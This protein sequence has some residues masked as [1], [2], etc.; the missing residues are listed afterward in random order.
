MIGVQLP[1]TVIHHDCKYQQRHQT[2][3]SLVVTKATQKWCLCWADQLE[4]DM[5]LNYCFNDKEIKQRCSFMYCEIFPK[6]KSVTVY[7]I[8]RVQSNSVFI[9]KGV[10]FNVFRLK[11]HCL[12][13]MLSRCSMRIITIDF[14]QSSKRELISSVKPK[15]ICS[16]RWEVTSLCMDAFSVHPMNETIDFLW[17]DKTFAFAVVFSIR[18][19]FSFRY[20]LIGCQE[21]HDVDNKKEIHS[22]PSL[23]K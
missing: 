14:V 4:D 9:L 23:L 19:Y 10:W 13:N 11:H 21:S 12:Q 16:F 17:N 1:R 5:E 22:K 8:V 15:N 18:T 20:T 2:I 3:C 7:D 6:N